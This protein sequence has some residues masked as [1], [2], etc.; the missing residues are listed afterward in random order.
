MTHALRLD[1]QNAAHGQLLRR[2]A[3]MLHYM[4]AVTAGGRG[5]VQEGVG[6][7]GMEEEGERLGYAWIK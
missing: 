6:Y 5:G 2:I 4:A 1:A 3:L 7:L